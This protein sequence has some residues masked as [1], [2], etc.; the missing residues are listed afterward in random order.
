MADR[1][2]P[3]PRRAA[4]LPG[5]RNGDDQSSMTVSLSFAARRWASTSSSS[6]MVLSSLLASRCA[7]VLLVV[8]T[9]V[10][11]SLAARR[12][13]S[14]SLGCSRRRRSH[15]R[16]PPGDGLR[17]RARPRGSRVDRPWCAPP[18][19]PTSKRVYPPD[20]RR[21]STDCSIIGR[22][23]SGPR[24]RGAAASVGWSL[25][26]TPSRISIARWYASRFVAPATPG[27]T[28]ARL[29]SVCTRAG[30]SGPCVR[31]LISRACRYGC[32]GLLGSPRRWS[33][34]AGCS[35]SPR[36]PDARCRPL[37][38]DHAT[39]CPRITA[40]SSSRRI[41]RI[42]AQSRADRGSPQGGS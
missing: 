32:L 11:S 19:G 10:S 38:R 7:Y 40:A 18:V 39:P 12:W 22:R 4:R 15:R 30:A 29:F 31:S 14:T 41:E 3:R 8:S 28:V 16:W 17:R 35:A 9:T 33:T 20:W 23:P 34:S 1:D 25:A 13:P 21:Y 36:I 6:T 26:T 42:A 37:T 5:L 27:R 2:D 24:F